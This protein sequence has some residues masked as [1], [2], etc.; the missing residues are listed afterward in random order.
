MNGQN[1]WLYLIKRMVYR[2]LMTAFRSLRQNFSYFLLFSMF[3]LLMFVNSML[4]QLDLSIEGDAAGAGNAAEKA[5]SS[6]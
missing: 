4:A 2:F 1:R 6:S 5:C 3:P